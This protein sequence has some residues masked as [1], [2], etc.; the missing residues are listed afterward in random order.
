MVCTEPMDAAANDLTERLEAVAWES[1]GNALNVH[2]RVVRLA[3][4]AAARREIGVPA[5]LDRA[6]ASGAHPHS[7][8]A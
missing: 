7:S 3:A 8:T 4:A 6:P 2:L 5:L 1:A